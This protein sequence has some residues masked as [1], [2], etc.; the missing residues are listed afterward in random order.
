M[1]Q[2]AVSDG[3]DEMVNEAVWSEYKQKKKKAFYLIH[4]LEMEGVCVVC[5]AKRVSSHVAD[6][7]NILKLLTADTSLFIKLFA[8]TYMHSHIVWSSNQLPTFWTHY[9]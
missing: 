6:K 7:R 3:V 8:C 4:H 5:G 2:K 1:C 9:C